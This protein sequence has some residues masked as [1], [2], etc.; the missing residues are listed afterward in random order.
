[1]RLSFR[2]ASLV[3]AHTGS[4]YPDTECDR[5]SFQD[6]TGGTIMAKNKNQKQERRQPSESRGATPRG[7]EPMK[8]AANEAPQD[9]P[10]A[11]SPGAAPKGKAGRKPG[12]E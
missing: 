6:P 3:S 5:P 9:A 12:R 1:M 2:R 7:Q 8:P 11:Q 4:Q 10:M